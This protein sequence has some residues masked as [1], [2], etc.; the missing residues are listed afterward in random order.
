MES[1]KRI[2]EYLRTII[3]VKR[4]LAEKALKDIPEDG[5][6]SKTTMDKLKARID[7][8]NEFLSELD[9]CERLTE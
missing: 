4:S 6:Y 9:E 5:S 2:T 1:N 3:K 7:V 8:Y